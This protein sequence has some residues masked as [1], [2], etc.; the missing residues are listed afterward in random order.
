MNVAS[1]ARCSG[2]HRS[3]VPVFADIHL[4]GRPPAALGLDFPS[5]S[6]HSAR[7]NAPPRSCA[8][9]W[10]RKVRSLRRSAAF[11]RL[12]PDRVHNPRAGSSPFPA[13]R[14]AVAPRASRRSLHSRR[15][16]D[17]AR[18]DAVHCG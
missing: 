12:A 18:R 10:P 2:I 1:R 14:A 3:M 15:R 11:L 17:I 7:E 5:F 4:C 16:S 9:R 6:L 13:S 8:R